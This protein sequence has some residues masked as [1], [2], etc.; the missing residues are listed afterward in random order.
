MPTEHSAAEI[1]ATVVQTYATCRSYREEGDE[2][3]VFITG[4]SPWQRR[5]TRK[6]F[7]TEFVR[8]DRLFFEY[9]EVGIGPESEWHRGVIWTDAS[10]VHAWNTLG[11][12]SGKADSISAA[13]GAMSGL[14]N[15]TSSFAS[16]L[17]LPDL[18]GHAPLPDPLTA[19]LIGDEDVDGLV[20]HRIEGVRFGKQ[21]V[22]VWIERASSLVRRLSSGTEFNEETFREQRQMLRE[23]LAKM[24][25]DDPK[26]AVLEKALVAHAERTAQSFRTEATATRRAAVNV[27]I[28]ESVFAFTPPM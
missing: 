2:C 26:R 18:Q 15:S 5:T 7:R 11:I 12:A 6:Q 20:C 27:E 14:S 17:L 16:K 25:A 9:R 4:Q 28:D 10:G 8:P 23:S 21:K 19:R 22:T 24:P 3:T 1:L 13:V